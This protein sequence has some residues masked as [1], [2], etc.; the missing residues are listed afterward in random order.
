MKSIRGSILQQ[1]SKIRPH[2]LSD[3]TVAASAFFF[4]WRPCP[5]APVAFSLKRNLLQGSAL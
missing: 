1:C 5:A 3:V 2:S 4:M